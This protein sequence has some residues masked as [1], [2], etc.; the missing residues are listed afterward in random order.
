MQTNWLHTFVVAA[1]HEHFHRA[2]EVLFISQPTVTGHIRQLETSLGCEL[3][4]KRGRGIYLTEEGRLFLP[5]AKDMLALLDD[6]VQELRNYKEGYE[7]TF[8]IAVSP[9]VADTRLAPW[10]REYRRRVSQRVRFNVLVR[11]SEIIG[12]LVAE[13]AADL[14]LSRMAA[15]QQQVE[16]LPLYTEAVRCI[17]PHDGGDAESSPPVTL[18]DCVQTMPLLTGN[19]PE[20]WT[21]LL[22]MLHHRFTGLQMMEVSQIHITKRFVEEG[23][24]FSFLP[25][26]AVRRE[27]LEG[28]VLDIPTKE[29]PSFKTTTYAVF[30]QNDTRSKQLGDYFHSLG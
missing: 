16:N 23:L 3:F 11:E 10:L 19:H 1:A 4:S 5:K 8:T 22:E 21:P 9:V 30:R 26:S 2:A 13:G 7:E 29:L 6:G 27:L 28:R 14:G 20:Y 18:A 12:Q 15:L 24:G 17:A 25:S